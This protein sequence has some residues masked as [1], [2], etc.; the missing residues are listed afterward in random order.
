M[1]TSAFLKTTRCS[2]GTGLEETNE[3]CD[4]RSHLIQWGEENI[5]G[6]HSCTGIEKSRLLLE[7]I[8][9]EESIGLDD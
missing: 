6:E 8:Q 1:N 2:L 9:E 4:E 5:L 3:T 7:F